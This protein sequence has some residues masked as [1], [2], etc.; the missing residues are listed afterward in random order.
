MDNLEILRKRLKELQEQQEQLT[1]E[2]R[3]V[4]QSQHFRLHVYLPDTVK[5]IYNVD[6]ELA[7]KTLDGDL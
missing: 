7:R 4:S 5:V 3:E 2:L 1:R 6:N